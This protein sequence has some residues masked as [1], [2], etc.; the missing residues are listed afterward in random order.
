[1]VGRLQL[2]APGAYAPF[3]LG[4]QRPGQALTVRGDGGR[5]VRLRQQPRGA[6]LGTAR[7]VAGADI[8]LGGVAVLEE[9]PDETDVAGRE[10]L[11]G[12]GSVSGY[13]LDRF[14]SRAAPTPISAPTMVVNFTEGQ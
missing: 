6:G 11:V 2:S 1:M 3:D 5:D 7:R 10:E 13:R 14:Y 9:F 8:G 12:Q 4:L